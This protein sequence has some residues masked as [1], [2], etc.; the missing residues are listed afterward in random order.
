MEHTNIQLVGDTPKFYQSFLDL[1]NEKFEIDPETASDVSNPGFRSTLMKKNNDYR[2][3]EEI[4]PYVAPLVKKAQQVAV[5]ME[6]YYVAEDLMTK[7]HYMAMKDVLMIDIDSYKMPNGEDVKILDILPHCRCQIEAVIAGLK[8][9]DDINVGEERAASW[10]K[11]KCRNMGAARG[12]VGKRGRVEPECTYR[13]RLF[14]SRAGWHAFVINKE[15]EYRSRESMQLMIE[16]MADYFYVIFSYL[17][18]WC[19]RLNRKGN[20]VVGRGGLYPEIGDV[21]RGRQVTRNNKSVPI[22]DRA[23]RLIDLHIELTVQ[24]KDFAPVRTSAGGN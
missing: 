16:G 5:D 18:S 12:M 24:A 11:H 15:M 23:S 2:L 7:T 19:V 4:A 9:V 13:Y 14:K 20:E 1:N 8:S 6:D 3:I 10:M 17:R 22:V 21:I